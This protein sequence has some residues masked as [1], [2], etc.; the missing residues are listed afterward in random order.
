MMK[1]SKI[2]CFAVCFW[3][4]NYS[5]AQLNIPDSRSY[6]QTIY[7][8]YL[9]DSIKGPNNSHLSLKPIHESRTST[10]T[11]FKDKGDYY[12]WIT[13]KLF[14]AHFLIFEGEDFWCAVDPIIDLEIGK[15]FEANEQSLRF[16][17]TRGIR[18]QAKF[19]TNFGFET[20]IYETQALLPDYQSAYINNHGEFIVNG[21]NYNQVNAVIPGY[22]RTKPFN[23]DGY[24]FAF[25]RGYF[26]Y[27][28]TNWLNIEAGNG[29]HFVG[30]GHR[31]LLLSN[32]AVNYPYIKSELLFLNNKLQYSSIYASQQ[33][34]YRL[35]VYSTPEANY[36][37]KLSVSHYVDYSINKNIQIGIFENNM[38][39][40]SD[41]LGVKPFNY[42]AFN[43]LIGNTL[44][45]GGNTPKRFNGFFGLNASINFSKNLIYGQLVFNKNTFGGWQL[46]IN[47]YN[48]LLQ[49]LN[50]QIEFNQVRENFYSSENKR[51]NYTHSN[52]ALAH[53]LGNNFKE[54]ILITDYTYKRIFVNYTTIYSQRIPSDSTIQH[55][56]LL[57]SVQNENAVV[58]VWFNKLEAGY[59]FNKKYNL[60]CYIGILNR[61]S[62]VQNVQ[63]STNFAYFGIKTNLSRKTLDW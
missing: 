50:L 41:S 7:Q 12:Y 5:F 17:N 60:E 48:I 13:Q 38:W 53:P 46:G 20:S 52:L 54:I 39:I 35:P 62:T 30:H 27:Q 26:N 56:T 22:S 59:R 15:D 51:A 37:R 9:A 47:K 49:N 25:A 57:S 19:F 44:F 55:Q 58:N 43:P 4:I 24:D 45:D 1:K 42:L 14:K 3:I 34:L 40:T 29:N 32:F 2:V 61:I 23:T 6:T 28:P 16:W 33:N 63:N 31:S 10:A 8:L 11:I 36:E 18:V 21:N